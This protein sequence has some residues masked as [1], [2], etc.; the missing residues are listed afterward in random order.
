[1]ITISIDN[2]LEELEKLI[3]QSVEYLYLGQI[4]PNIIEDMQL[5]IEEVVS[6]II[7]YAYPDQTS[8]S[9]VITL[10]VT[11]DRIISTFED[12]GVA[13]N[14]LQI[15]EEQNL[16]GEKKKDTIGGWGIILVQELSDSIKYT[17]EDSKNLLLVEK[18]Y[19]KTF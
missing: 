8:E 2:K 18:N 15:I 1:M 10:N 5:I 17:R 11:D 13:F 4:T 7:K 6:N 12:Y 19:K 14:P 16:A 9:I 3:N